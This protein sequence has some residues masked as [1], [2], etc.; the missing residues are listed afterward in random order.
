MSTVAT[1]VFAVPVTRIDEP[2]PVAEEEADQQ[3][4]IVLGVSVSSRWYVGVKFAQ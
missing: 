2:D 1:C 4:E 3:L